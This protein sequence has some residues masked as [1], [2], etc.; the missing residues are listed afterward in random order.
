MI[1]SVAEFARL[2]SVTSKERAGFEATQVTEAAGL[3]IEA[4]V[5]RFG[6]RFISV[7][8]HAYQSPWT[9]LEETLSGQIEFIGDELCG[10]SL[11][12]EGQVTWVY[13]PSTNTAIRK[14]GSQLFEPLPG[15]ATLGELAFLETLTQDFLL[16]DMGEQQ[17]DQQAVRQVV[18]KPKQAFRSQLLSSMTF[19]IRKATIDFDM[20]T[21]FPLNISFVPSSGSPVA[22]IVGTDAAIRISYKDVRV[23]ESTD[24]A[25]PFAPP[26]D[27]HVF[28]ESRVSI[29]DLPASV[30]FPMPLH[31]LSDHGFETGEWPVLLTIDTENE[32]AYAAAH[33]SA[34]SD[35]SEEGAQPARLALSLGNY[36][37]RNMA[38]RRT[39]FSEMGKPSSQ[40]SLPVKLLDRS[41]LWEQ[42]LPGIDAQHAPI[43]A[44]FEKDGVFWFLSA[45]GI[46]ID[47]MEE[48]VHDLFEAHAAEASQSDAP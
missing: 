38:R 6:A 12:C 29:Q 47:A 8:Y 40:D 46:A 30:P 34:A 35:S 17:V 24:S 20:E 27:A 13:D 2:A 1:P 31:P 42:Q 16:R 41:G 26:A 32:R 9:E 10:L 11:H 3:K 43:E 36:M 39:T 23:L 25:K 15:L 44:F 33:F 4:A 19:P 21:L 14:I 7:E 45:T 37:S 28:Q 22:S 48:L 18:V 5:R